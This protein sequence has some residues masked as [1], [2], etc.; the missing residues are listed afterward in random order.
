MPAIDLGAVYA[1]VKAEIAAD[2]ATAALLANAPAARGGG[3]A[4]YDDGE[5]P[6]PTQAV[7]MS[8]LT[9]LVTVGAGTAVQSSTLRKRGWNC[10]VQVKVIA[11]GTEATVQAIVAALSALFLPEPGAKYVTVAGFTS[12]W[13]ADVSVQPTLLELVGGVTTRSVPVILRVYAT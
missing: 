10:S 12:S 2:V 13:V 1:A 5:A 11:Q 6:Q 4:I 7:P 8:T 9:P 3:K